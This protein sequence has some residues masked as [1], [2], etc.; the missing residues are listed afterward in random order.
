MVDRIEDRENIKTLL[1]GFL[2]ITSVST[3][4]RPP[5]SSKTGDITEL[6]QSSQSGHLGLKEEAL[7]ELWPQSWHA[8]GISKASDRPTSLDHIRRGFTKF[9][10]LHGDRVYGDDPSIIAGLGFLGNSAV[11]IIGHEKAV[12]YTHLTLPTSDLV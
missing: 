2:K 4:A 7:E 9:I 1:S 3:R 10:E 8:V 12:S 5:K 11:G 6:A